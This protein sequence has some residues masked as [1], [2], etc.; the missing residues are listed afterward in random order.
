LCWDT[1]KLLLLLLL[2]LPLL[3]LLLPLLL[4]L[5]CAVATQGIDGN[6]RHS[7]RGVARTAP[8]KPGQSQQVSFSLSRRDFKLAR[9]ADGALMLASGIW[10]VSFGVWDAPLVSDITPVVLAPAP[11]LIDGGARAA[12]APVVAAA[13]GAVIDMQQQRQQSQQSGQGVQ[14]RVVETP[15]AAA[16]PPLAAAPGA[17]L[18]Q[19]QQQ[20]GLQLGTE[21]LA[22]PAAAGTAAAAPEP[23]TYTGGPVALPTTQ[24][25]MSQQE[26]GQRYTADGQSVG[27]AGA[28]DKADVE[29]SSSSSSWQNSAAA[30]SSSSSRNGVQ[31]QGLVVVDS[32][33]GLAV[34]IDV[35]SEP[36]W[37]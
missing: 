13:P 34:T 7:L 5:R 19:Q 31:Q 14:V 4:L 17:V 23:V 20:Q 6:P 12:P 9:S 11:P 22:A 27:R 35:P 36:F 32:Q 33:R 16:P 21:E 24:G 37:T 29:S 25:G 15:A 30:A 3:L 18:A 2:L 1:W 10:K 26:A 8:L 28:A